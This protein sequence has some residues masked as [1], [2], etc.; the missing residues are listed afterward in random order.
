MWWQSGTDLDYRPS[1]KFSLLSAWQNADTQ[2]PCMPPLVPKTKGV[3]DL[4]STSST[5]CWYLRF[6][7]S[8]CSLKTVV[9]GLFGLHLELTCVTLT[10]KYAVTPRD[11]NP[12]AFMSNPAP[13]LVKA[14]LKWNHSLSRGWRSGSTSTSVLHF[15]SLVYFAPSGA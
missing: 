3:K 8:S 1:I 14:L 12:P 5:C 7:S 4:I 13:E 6:F 15:T 2:Y 10:S 9:V 11:R